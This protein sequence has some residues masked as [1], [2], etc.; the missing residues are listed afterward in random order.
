MDMEHDETS[1][2]ERRLMLE[3]SGYFKIHRPPSVL[4]GSGR[5]KTADKLVAV[6]HAL[7]LESSS[8][9]ALADMCSEIATS[10]TD[11]G[12]EFSIMRAQPVPVD[13]V[14]PWMQVPDPELPDACLAITDGW[15]CM[16]QV[17]G[18][19]GSPPLSCERALPASGLLHM[20]SNIGAQL[21]DQFDETITQ[22]SHVSDLLRHSG[23]QTR[24]LERS[25]NDL[26]GRQLWPPIKSFTG[27]VHR[28]RWGT[29]AFCV[30]EMR[31]VERALRWGVE[32]GDI[33]RREC[34]SPGRGATCL[35][36]KTD[37]PRDSPAFFASSFPSPLQIRA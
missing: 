10:T 8:P 12:V 20:I 5:T 21:A 15:D 17:I 4:L 6:A 35:C 1:S 13:Q 14:L 30:S 18:L 31:K 36:V 3:L 32:H 16:E 29:V 24:L 37:L 23:S 19:E 9:G 22:L 28:A 27:H 33:Q 7:W 26:V 25:F 34:P 2:T 11:M